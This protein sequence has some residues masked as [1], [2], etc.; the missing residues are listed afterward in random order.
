MKLQ[1][2]ERKFRLHKIICESSNYFVVLN[3]LNN[4]IVLLIIK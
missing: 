1:E 2:Q 3:V 4:F